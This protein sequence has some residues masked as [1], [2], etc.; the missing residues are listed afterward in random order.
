VHC[1]PRIAVV[2]PA[3]KHAGPQITALA[4][5]VGIRLDEEQQYLAEVT[6]GVGADG[7]W[8][9]FEAVMFG[10]RQSLGKTE[11][12]L[13]R[14]LA[15]L[16]L[17]GEELLAYS[18]HR[19]STTSKTHRRLCRA[20]DRNPALGA[21]IA[22]K[23]NRLGAERLELTT[24]QAVEMFARSTSSGRGFVGDFLG[25]DESHDL[26]PDALAAALPMLATRPNP[27]VLYGASMGTEESYHLA[28]LRK[29]ALEGK[30]DVAWLEWSMGDDE[31]IDDRSVWAR[32][33]PGYPARISMRAMEKEFA[34]LG[35]ERFARERLG[36]SVWPTGEP[37]EWLTVSEAVWE[38]CGAPGDV[39]IGS[40]LRPVAA[41]APEPSEAPWESWPGLVPPWIRRPRS[42]VPAGL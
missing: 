8:A 5:M 10:P 4:A 11:Y 9:A 29:R 19:A 37:G 27:Q 23:S 21:R 16:F 14:L 22:R 38:A 35:P 28:A 33:N 42:A 30:S 24:G 13:V 41:E 12:F 39:G 1:E 40:L 34:A 25:L 6:S 7:K 32:C 36:K 2:P 3:V 18:A 26:D 15:G 17:F 31:R 20:I